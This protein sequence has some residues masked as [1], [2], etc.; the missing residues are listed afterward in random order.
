M[1]FYSYRNIFL[2]CRKALFPQRTSFFVAFLMLLSD[3]T[4]RF[5][6]LI[7]RTSEFQVTEFSLPICRYL[8]FYTLF[9]T[10]LICRLFPSRYML[11]LVLFIISSYLEECFFFIFLPFNLYILEPFS[12]LN[13]LSL[14]C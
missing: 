8:A 13:G 4:R 6:L 14:F 1:P 10:L 2:I 9:I 12:C 5:N 3:S 7:C 11:S